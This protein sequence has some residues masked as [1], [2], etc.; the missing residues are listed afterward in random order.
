LGFRGE[1]DKRRWGGEKEPREKGKKNN[2]GREPGGGRP[3]EEGEDR[4]ESGSFKKRGAIARCTIAAGAGRS[5]GSRRRGGRET[6]V[7]AM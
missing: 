3:L 4:G 7:N 5:V 1:K 6:G 2:E